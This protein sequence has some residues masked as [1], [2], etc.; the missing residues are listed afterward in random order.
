MGV[1]KKP[2]QKIFHEVRIMRKIAGV[3]IILAVLAFNSVVSA[4]IKSGAVSV[5]PYIGGYL[6][7]GNQDLKHNPFYGLRFGY[8]FTRNLAAEAVFNYVNT[9]YQPTGTDTSA[10]VY[11]YRLEGL[12]HFMPEKRFVPFVAVGLG[13]Q[14]INYNDN[15]G[16]RVRGVA[17]YGA[18]FKYFFTDWLALRADVRHVLAFGSLYNNL[19]YGLGLTFYFGGS[20][21]APAELKQEPAMQPMQPTL[22]EP[23]PAPMPPPMPPP[24]P[25]VAVEEMKKAPEAATTIEKSII[26]K[27]RATLN[28]EFD[29]DKAIVKPRYHK[30]I[31]NVADVMVKYPDLNIVVEGHTDNVGGKQYN[32]NLSQKRAEAIKKVMETKFNINPGRITAKGFGFSR[33]V[34]SNSTKEGRQKNRRVEAAVE[35]TYTK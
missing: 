28:V 32:L 19:E 23:E 21:A 31:Q 20:K 11:N 13:G 7:E 3:F 33:P 15:T 2:S 14:T 5:S 1:I 18:G 24:A 35:Y 16:N 22:K 27:G 34:A 4:E 6:F 29:F 9:R 8:D 26:E 25:P 17:D 30:E 12:Y 10:N